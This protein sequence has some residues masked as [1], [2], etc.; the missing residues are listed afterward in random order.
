V[1]FA[2]FFHVLVS[3]F[4]YDTVL[5]KLKTDHVAIFLEEGPEVDDG[6]FVQLLQTERRVLTDGVHADLAL[7]QE[8]KAGCIVSPLNQV[9]PFK[10]LL[11]SHLVDDVALRIFTQVP[12]EVNLV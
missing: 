6:S 2:K 3:Q 5:L 11:P 8:E 12:E 9:F 10:V 7:L 4:K 1:L